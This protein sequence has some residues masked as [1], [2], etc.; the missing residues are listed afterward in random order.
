METKLKHLNT[1]VNLLESEHIEYSLGGSGLLYLLNLVRTVNDWDITLETPADKL[2]NALKGYS[3]ES[4]EKG[5]YPYATDYKL[6]LIIEKT[7]FEFIN[8]FSIHSDKGACSIPFRPTSIWN[9]IKIS[10]PEAWYTA[11]VLMGKNEKADLLYGHLMKY[12][13]NDSIINILKKQPLPVELHKTLD[14]L[15]RL[16]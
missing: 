12:G 1:I 10:S 2:I 15:N 7:E 6:K 13:A 16:S 4:F 14:S 9:G 8:K 3:I 5:S 11:Y